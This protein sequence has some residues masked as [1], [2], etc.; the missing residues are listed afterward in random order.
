MGR[1]AATR[2]S[3]DRGPV[4]DSASPTYASNMLRC[5]FM[6]FVARSDDPDLRPNRHLFGDGPRADGHELLGMVR[7]GGAELT[8]GLWVI[9]PFKI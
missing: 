7:W 4:G 1:K 3:R 2:R 9:G 8:V 5:Y 6:G